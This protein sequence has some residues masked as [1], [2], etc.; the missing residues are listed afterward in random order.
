MYRFNRLL[1]IMKNQEQIINGLFNASEWISEMVGGDLGDEENGHI[2]DML[3]N[4]D[5]AINIIQNLNDK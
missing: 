4:I 2:L 1:K 5:E 3:K